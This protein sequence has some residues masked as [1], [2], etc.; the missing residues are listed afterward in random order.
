MV[1]L[2][3][4][5]RRAAQVPPRTAALLEVIS[6]QGRRLLAPRAVYARC[7]VTTT[8]DGVTAI[9]G[10]LRAPSRSLAGCLRGCRE[11]VLFAATIGPALDA[12]IAELSAAGEMTR[13]LLAD[14]YA[15]AAAIELGV[16]VE[17]I[18]GRQL[19]ESGL[20]PGRRCAPGY[21]DWDLADQAPLL[22][23]LDAAR[24]GIALSEDAMM[25]PMKS[26]SGVIGG[27]S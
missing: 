15:S 18:L 27:R 19:E 1:R 22:R 11:A 17:T 21:G 14:A 20:T 13:S 16:E 25:T 5:Y 9:T 10:V 24:I 3:L 23:H 2:R 4:G 12:W 26:I 6:E 8:R 7:P